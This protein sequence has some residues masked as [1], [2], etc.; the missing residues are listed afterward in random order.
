M[1]LEDP[2]DKGT[3]GQ[4]T[5][6]GRTGPRDRSSG[7]GGSGGTKKAGNATVAD[8]M[9]ATGKISVP[10]IGPGGMNQ[11][12]Y[13]SQD[14]AYTDYARAIGDYATRGT[15]GKIADALFGGWY[16]QMEPISQNPRTFAGGVY[17]SA[18]NPGSIAGA[19]AGG[20]INPAL[21]QITGPLGGWAYNQFGGKN[22]FHGGYNQPDTGVYSDPAN[23]WGGGSAQTGGNGA[24][25]P[26]NAGN[27]G[28]ESDKPW[29][30]FTPPAAPQAPQAAAPMPG[31]PT[32]PTANPFLPQVA[33]K[34][35]TSTFTP[36][37]MA[38]PFPGQVNTFKPSW[39]Q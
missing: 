21:G 1:A 11:G 38:L 34:P 36:F 28:A 30:P 35:A 26:G 8:H 13:P 31:A 5:S 22:V 14:D 12:N 39:L 6:E 10:S 24:S 19:L 3:R 4:R 20:A 33:T 7:G 15:L 9:I 27:R 37:P 25:A 32:P 16:D 29:D 18:S 2:R 17:H 23:G